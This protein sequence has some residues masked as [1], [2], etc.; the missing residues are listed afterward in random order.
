MSSLRRCALVVAV[1]APLIAGL[2][3][4]GVGGASPTPNAIRV[5]VVKE[6]WGPQ[7]WTDASVDT[8]MQAVEQF[9]AT[10]SFGKVA[11]SYT[12]TPWLDV[13]PGPLSCVDEVAQL[14][15]LA[16]SA[17][18]NPAAYDR[19]VYLVPIGDGRGCVNSAFQGADVGVII[20]A[21]LL[22]VGG[23]IHELGHS[24]DMGHAG[25]LTCWYQQKKRLC[26]GDSYGDTVDVMGGTGTS[27]VLAY[28]GDFGAVQKALAGWLTPTYITK[29]GTYRLAPLEIASTLPQAL[30]IRGSF[31]EYWI[32]ARQ[33]V[34]NDAHLGGPA[35]SGFAVHRI[36]G[37]PL[38][39]DAP[40]LPVDY[41]VPSARSQTYYTAPGKTFSLPGV[42]TLTALSRSQ[43]GVV[44]VRYREVGS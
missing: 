26:L 29:P 14:P 41:L 18:W 9:Y 38:A 1:A 10:G 23:M 11:I 35:V 37:D 30:V 28:T 42:F 40:W 17:G 15:Q 39:P 3:I 12:Q 20:N 36:S 25:L 31:Y 22:P 5:L 43:A 6:T 33:P 7:P 32:D 27:N 34:G 8:V 24:F 44:T 16:A 4:V 19:V 21:D 2:L 13:M